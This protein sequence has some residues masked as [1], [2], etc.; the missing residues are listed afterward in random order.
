[1]SAGPKAASEPNS[2]D[3]DMASLKLYNFAHEMIFSYFISPSRVQIKT[4][5]FEASFA[6][7][8]TKNCSN[9][10]VVCNGFLEE[11]T[12]FFEKITSRLENKRE[13]HPIISISNFHSKMFHSKKPYFIE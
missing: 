13:P 6:V 3:D 5:W 7:L 10:T 9:E 12:F 11:K 2:K 4:L 8:K 1:V